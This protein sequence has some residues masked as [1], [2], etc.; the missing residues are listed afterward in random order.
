MVDALR[1][2]AM[3]AIRQ[4][5][6]QD[7]TDNLNEAIALCQAMPYPYAEA[8]ALWVYGR[9]EVARGDPAAARECF[10]LAL[11][12]CDRLGEGL[13]RPHIEQALT[14]LGQAT[15]SARRNAS[16]QRLTGRRESRLRSRVTSSATVRR[17]AVL[18][19][20]H[21]QWLGDVSG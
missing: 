4:D 10:T 6:W 17:V 12:I 9:L 18:P 3:L 11:A 8:K 13:Y 15:L 7:A 1:I 19:L 20:S 14:Q 16:A 21:D 2:Q 5:R